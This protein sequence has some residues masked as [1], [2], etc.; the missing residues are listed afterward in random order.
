MAPT[1]QRLSF[2]IIFPVVELALFYLSPLF[3]ILLKRQQDL[4]RVLI[5]FLG[6]QSLS[7]AFS[8]C[9]RLQNWR[10]LGFSPRGLASDATA[11][12]FL[13]ALAILLSW[14]LYH[15]F[16]S[17]R[18]GLVFF[19]IALSGIL[20]S[21][22][23]VGLVAAVL[24]ICF[25]FFFERK[26]TLSLALAA[27]FLAALLLSFFLS[28]HRFS[29]SLATRLEVN[30]QDAGRVILDHQADRDLS[31]ALGANRNV[32]WRYAWECLR[33]FPLTGVGTGNFVFWVMSAHRSDYFHHLTANQYFFFTSSLGLPGLAAFLLFCLALFSGR[34]WPEKCL[35]AAFMLFFLFND[36]L[37]F[38]E[39]ALLFWLVVAL[40]K[41][42]Q[43]NL[44]TSSRTIRVL[45]LAGI[46][47]FVFLHIHEFS[48]L[49]PKNWAQ[50]NA[51][52][53]D[54]GLSYPES[55]KGRQF[56]WS[57]ERAGIY[58]TLDENGRNEN[59]RLACGAPLARLESKKQTV[60]I[61]WRGKF[62]KRLVF[63][64]HAEYPIRIDDRKHRK[65]FLEF[66]VRPAF[67]LKQM[68]LGDETRT[69]G[70]RLF[71]S[72]YPGIQVIAPNGGESLI[73]GSIQDIRWSSR[74]TIASV[75][76]EISYDD[77]R[78]YDDDRRF[79]RE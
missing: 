13:S 19:F 35:L 42:K 9:Q 76:I 30:I 65:G 28:P 25:F 77:G 60:D 74:G 59:Y 69:L 75:K 11:F 37:W 8:F 14:Y 44:M 36:Y 5:A 31:S 1:G 71:G 70:V 16:G 33:E 62:Y 3:Y 41:E 24:A 46:V 78:T 79:H 61:Y 32:L 52:S 7:I 2:G 55:E 34:P 48:D 56:Q 67:N 47:A 23:R 38:S 18:L 40:G 72:D 53:Y 54:Y 26:K 51:V 22:T 12:G 10:T 43:D 66:R 50:A 4:R 63:R 21:S 20:N 73:P 6:G 68:G 39:I 27:A 49:H 45:C 57:A 58:I 15:R 17:R 29:S 64:D